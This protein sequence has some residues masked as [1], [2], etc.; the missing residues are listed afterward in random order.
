MTSVQ[1]AVV[2][3]AEPR[4]GGRA[5]PTPMKELGAHPT[6]G[7]A[8]KLME[9]RYGPYVTDGTTNATVPK[10]TDPMA[11]ALDAAAALID[12]RAAAGPAKGKRKAKVPAK[13]AAPAKKPAAPKKVVGK[14]PAAKRSPAKAS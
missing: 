1:S 6:S 5:A 12:A 7:A 14:K 9:G 13:R 3:L 4:G 8:L 2:K 10:G 11:L